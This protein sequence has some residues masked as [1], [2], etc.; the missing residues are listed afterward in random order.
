MLQTYIYL[1]LFRLASCGSSV[2]LS[3]SLKG[4]G[5]VT[6]NLRSNVPLSSAVADLSSFTS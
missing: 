4:N 6:D 2:V 3:G 1:F 5:F